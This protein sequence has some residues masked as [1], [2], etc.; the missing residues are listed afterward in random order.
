MKA[1]RLLYLLP[2]IALFLPVWMAMRAGVPP[3]E[4]LSQVPL[5]RHLWG[6]A[7]FVLDTFLQAVRLVLL[8]RVSG[9]RL[10]LG[11]AAKANLA[12]E[13]AGAVTPARGGSDPSRIFFLCRYG[14]PL[15]SAA[16]AQAGAL[17]AE[18]IGVAG[19]AVLAAFFLPQN[20]LIIVGS[21]LYSLGVFLLVGGTIW[22]ASLGLKKGPPG[23]FGKGKRVQRLWGWILVH[24]SQFRERMANLSRIDGWSLAW[25]MILTILHIGARLA[26][27][28][29]LVWEDV[30]SEN[31]MALLAWPLL[32]L[33][34]GA[35]LPLPGG[36]GIVELGLAM[37]L[38][39]IASL[40]ENSGTV[41][42]WR[43]YTLWLPAALG[44]IFWFRLSAIKTPW[45]SPGAARSASGKEE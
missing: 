2:A 10:S 20:E 29:L 18:A 36:G 11:A 43:F 15:A 6:I 1:R 37:G 26:V 3:S 9:V 34:A 7:A 30:G 13:A 22:L 19:L 41:F 28:P 35:A 12:G 5:S 17:I 32:F 14:S 27:L 40:G 42:W 24:G 8:L 44:G 39:G 45:G 25:V 31:G 33:Y 4:M 38:R 21:L 23:I 16:T